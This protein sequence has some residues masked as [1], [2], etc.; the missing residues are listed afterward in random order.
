MC[1]FTSKDVLDE[2]R[3]VE[4]A[5][6][7]ANANYELIFDHPEYPSETLPKVIPEDPRYWHQR[8]C[9]VNDPTCHRLMQCSDCASHDSKQGD[10]TYYFLNEEFRTCKEAH[11]AATR[12]SQAK[13][14][15]IHI[16]AV[17]MADDDP[18]CTAEVN[19]DVAWE[20]G[21]QQYPSCLLALQAAQA[22]EKGDNPD[23]KCAE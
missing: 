15:E 16:P 12:Y 14:N 13:Y 22:V 10:A 20:F 23:Y 8:Q 11:D 17:P 2:T 3:L 21:T 18:L 1:V 4:A 19:P 5:L 7:E 9:G 6:M